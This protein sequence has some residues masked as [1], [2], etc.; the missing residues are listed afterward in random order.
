MKDGYLMIADCRENQNMSGFKAPGVIA[1]RTDF[2]GSL[3]GDAVTLANLKKLQA[4]EHP[5]LEEQR[6]IERM[7]SEVHDERIS[8]EGAFLREA[9]FKNCNMCRV[10]FGNADLTGADFR[11]STMVEVDFS[12]CTLTDVNFEGV[13]L[14]TC[15]GLPRN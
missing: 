2:S 8:Y 10:S 14:S 3:M 9:K 11:G 12:G 6:E 7:T 5:S 1:Y 13:D 4:L 15:I